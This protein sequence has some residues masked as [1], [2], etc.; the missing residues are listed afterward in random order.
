VIDEVVVL[1]SQRVASIGVAY[2]NAT[3]DHPIANQ[4]VIIR[5]SPELRAWWHSAPSWRAW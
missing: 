1:L 2:L 3:N 4:R 5:A